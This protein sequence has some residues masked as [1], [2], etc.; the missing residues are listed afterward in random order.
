MITQSLTIELQ[1]FQG[2]D[3]VSLIL[4]ENNEHPTLAH[5]TRFT[6]DRGMLFERVQVEVNNVVRRLTNELANQLKKGQS[7]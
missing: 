4:T 7:T 6:L 2:V 3:K 1:A 5:Q